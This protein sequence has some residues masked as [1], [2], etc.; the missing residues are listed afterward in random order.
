MD[1]CNKYLSPETKKKQDYCD[2]NTTAEF[3]NI[4]KTVGI[5]DIIEVYNEEEKLKTCNLKKINLIKFW[6]RCF[7]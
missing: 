7:K 6:Q 4:N 2:E 5:N 1:D 3:K